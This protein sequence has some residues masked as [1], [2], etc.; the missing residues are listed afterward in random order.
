MK[1]HKS[2]EPSNFRLIFRLEVN[3]DSLLMHINFLYH[4][5]TC[6]LKI[7]VT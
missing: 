3:L 1:I 7:L 4:Y 5:L 2:H 6:I